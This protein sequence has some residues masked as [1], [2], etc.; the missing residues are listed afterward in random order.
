MGVDCISKGLGVNT[1]DCLG[2]TADGVLVFARREQS[3]ALLLELHIAEICRGIHV[4]CAHFASI[5]PGY[6]ANIDQSWVCCTAE[7]VNL[8]SAKLNRF[9][10]SGMRCA[11]EVLVDGLCL[12]PRERGV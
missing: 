3:I 6:W 9:S 7:V 1:Y 5:D 8:I 4:F 2:V 12:L 10:A 11:G